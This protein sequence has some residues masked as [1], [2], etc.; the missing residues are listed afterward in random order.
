M[1]NESV[2][3]SNFGTFLRRLREKRGLSLRQVGLKTGVSHSYLSQV[4]NQR[5]IPSA[6]ILS[7][8]SQVYRTDMTVLLEEAGLMPKKGSE[9]KIS[10]E[11]SKHTILPPVLKELT[12][13]KV[14]M[15][16][17]DIS[18]FEITRIAEFNFKRGAKLEK[19]EFLLFILFLRQINA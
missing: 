7:M 9:N 4:E 13:D 12:A 8:L 18:P 2:A 16:H 6:R 15:D 17:F 19:N 3:E 10:E 11:Q 14:I 5:K 1:K